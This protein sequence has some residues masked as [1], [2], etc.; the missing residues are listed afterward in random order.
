MPG[1]MNA[2]KALFMLLAILGLMAIACTSSGGNTA[3]TAMPQENSW[4]A[5]T[6]FIQQQLGISSLEAQRYNPD[7]VKTLADNQFEVTVY[8]AKLGTFYRCGILYRSDGN[9]QLISL[10]VVQ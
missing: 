1:M 5:C 8:Y 7:G 9:W 6:Q 10:K 3:P 2:M 4:Y